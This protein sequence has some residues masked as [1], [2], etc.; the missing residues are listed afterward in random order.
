MMTPERQGWLQ[1]ELGDRLTERIV[2]G[3]LFRPRGAWGDRPMRLRRFAFRHLG[4]GE[5]HPVERRMALLNLAVAT[6]ERLLLFRLGGSW[7]RISVEDEIAGWPLGE[8]RTSH[9]RHRVESKRFAASAGSTFTTME[10]ES[11][12]RTLRIEPTR[13]AALEIDLADSRDANALLE[14]LEARPGR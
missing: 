12:L 6:P 2:A 11:K 8:L 1:V 4:L 14:A 13:E 9:E 10:Y 5:L 7:R 3:E